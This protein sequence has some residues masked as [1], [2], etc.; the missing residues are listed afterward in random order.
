MVSQPQ[1]YSVCTHEDAF[2]NNYVPFYAPNEKIVL[3]DN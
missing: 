1:N 3:P 2:R